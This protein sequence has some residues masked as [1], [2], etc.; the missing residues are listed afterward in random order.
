VE[1]GKLVAQGSL[2]E[3]QRRLRPHRRL[4]IT[5]LGRA[6]EAQ[7]A[8]LGRDGVQEV[9]LAAAPA[10]GAPAAEG[11]APV[12]AAGAQTIEVDFSG[13]DE[14]VSALLRELVGR[15]LPVLRF[16]ESVYDLEDVFM[17]ATKGIVS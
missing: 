9:R 3:M 2:E 14:A 16:T 5:L 13:G 10:N 6:D 12:E 17:Q 8:L 11:A 4:H 7:A 15:G 1:A